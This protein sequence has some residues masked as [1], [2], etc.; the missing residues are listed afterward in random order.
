[1]L[2]AKLKALLRRAAGPTI[3]SLWDAIGRLLGDFSAAECS[4]YLA[5][6]GYGSIKVKDALGSAFVI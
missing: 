4:H 1:M 2:F 3:A 5:R 6:A